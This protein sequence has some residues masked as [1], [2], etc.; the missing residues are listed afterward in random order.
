MNKYQ[1]FHQ[2]HKQE[3]LFLLPNAWDP[4][5]ARILADAGFAAIATTSWGMAQS[6]GQ[7][8]GEQ[9]SF[10]EFISQLKP[11]I[12]AVNIAVSVDIESGYSNDVSTICQHVLAVAKL[13]A[14]GINIEDSDKKTAQLRS[15]EH[16][17]EILKAIKNTLKKY[18][19]SQLFINARTDCYSQNMASL[20]HVI[21]RSLAYQ[22]AGV[23][24]I[25]IPG[26]SDLTAIKQ[27]TTT[28]KVPLNVM[29]QP[30]KSDFLCDNSSNSSSLF[31][32]GVQRYTLGNALFDATK[33]Y[34]FTASST[35]N[36]TKSSDHL[37]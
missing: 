15:L 23:D 12:D 27:I 4:L 21:T 25:F 1:T 5:S 20:E 22:D 24:G 9:C 33:A 35:F 37:F 11:I 3:Q 28:L 26:L 13:G 18:G 10:E 29:A 16:Q 14:V 31:A 34:I 7:E 6:R 32:H 2:L 8:D 17:V 19:F 30:L 36:S